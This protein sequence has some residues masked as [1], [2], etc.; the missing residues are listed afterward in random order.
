MVQEIMQNGSTHQKNYK[1]NMKRIPY[2][3]KFVLF[4]FFSFITFH[5]KGQRKNLIFY[6]GFEDSTLSDWTSVEKCYVD[7]VSTNTSIKLVGNRSGRFYSKAV[8]S[9][10]C[11]NL[12]SQVLYQD[13]NSINYERWYGFSAYLGKSY[14]S[15]YDGVEFFMEFVRPDTVDYIP[16]GLTYEGY[17]VGTDAFLNTGNYL[18]AYAVRR[19][20]YDSHS[21]YTIFINPLRTVSNNQ[22]I[23]VVIHAKWSNNSSGLINIWVND[24]LCYNYTGPTNY[25]SQTLRLGIDKWDWRYNW[26]VSNTTERELYIDEFRIGD[27][28]ATYLDVTP[29]PPA[30]LSLKWLSFQV[31]PK[32]SCAL[33]SWDAIFDNNFQKFVVQ[34]S[35]DGYNWSNI[36]EVMNNYSNYYSFTDCSLR[37]TN[38]YRIK[39]V[40]VG[41]PDNFSTIRYLRFQGNV[42]QKVA[43]Y[44]E[45]GQLLMIKT[46]EPNYNLNDFKRSLN[47][48]PGFYVFKYEFGQVEKIIITN[49]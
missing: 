9:L 13:V 35:Y 10:G 40:S 11:T 47:L 36:G 45:L 18:G 32:N 21:P 33:L 6:S 8:D 20:P 1:K 39:S 29:N 28:L 25:T 43:V 4:I 22:W 19:T 44:N 46:I 17:F 34:K 42:P 7:R 12:R 23:N 48:K 38:F 49:R 3:I 14:P 41:E 24:T 27:S 15:F 37:L 26:Q 30:S 16:L 5:S 31:I 2:P